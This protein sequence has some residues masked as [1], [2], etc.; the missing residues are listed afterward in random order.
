MKDK[1]AIAL[2]AIRRKEKEAERK[3]E[4]DKVYNHMLAFSEKRG[5][6]LKVGKEQIYRR[7]KELEKEIMIKTILDSMTAVMYSLHTLFGFGHERLFKMGGAL[8]RILNAI[9]SG[10]RS[11]LKLNDEIKIETGLDIKNELFAGYTPFEGKA[12]EKERQQMAAAVAGSA[13]SGFI[14]CLYVIY[15]Y[16]GFKNIRLRRLA[17]GAREVFITNV[18][19]G[20]MDEIREVLRNKC[21]LMIS[22]DGR[23]REV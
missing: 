15:F 13:A 6:K 20:S 21:R 12:P 16:F 10:E 18:E 1:R 7:H 8:K 22:Q 9:A 5:V 19:A 17:E 3:C 11:M 23:V 4:V 14:P 2:K